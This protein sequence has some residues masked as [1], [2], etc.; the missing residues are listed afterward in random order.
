MEVFSEI[1]FEVKLGENIGV[2]LDIKKLNQPKT[3]IN[4]KI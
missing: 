1:K 2:K 3:R 4:E